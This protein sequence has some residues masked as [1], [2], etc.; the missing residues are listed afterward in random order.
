MFGA[1]RE[2]RV[3][4]KCKNELGELTCCK[5]YGGGHLCTWRARSSPR[6]ARGLNVWFFLHPL[7]PPNATQAVGRRQVWGYTEAC[8][9]LHCRGFL[10]AMRC[11]QIRGVIGGDF[12]KE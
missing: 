11:T 8:D 12:R 7:R 5:F 9:S 10:E 3:L 2:E 4:I 1:P 6:H